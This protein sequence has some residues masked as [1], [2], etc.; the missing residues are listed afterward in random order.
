[1]EMISAGILTNDMDMGQALAWAIARNTTGMKLQVFGG[2]GFAVSEMGKTDVL[3][4]DLSLGGMEVNQIMNS[5][6]CIIY[7]TDDIDL[8]DVS[9]AVLY[10]YKN[11]RELLKDIYHIYSLASGRQFVADVE[12]E[13]KIVSFVSE[14][15]GSGCTA[16]SLAFAGE[17]AKFRDKRV[18]HISL[19]QFPEDDVIFRKS[20]VEDD[21][22]QEGYADE[23]DTGLDESPGGA[24]GSAANKRNIK[25]YLYYILREGGDDAGKI[26]MTGNTVQRG[27]VRTSSFL[28]SNEDG[29]W[30]FLSAPGENPILELDE[31][32]YVKFIRRLT[33]DEEYDVLVID[34]GSYITLQ[35]IKSLQMSSRIV[36]V[37]DDRG[38][39]A[40]WRK[41]L[42]RITGDDL[43]SAIVPAQRGDFLAGTSFAQHL[44]YGII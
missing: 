43:K 12:H 6:A 2:T 44:V 10:K 27:R 8:E 4:T 29:V 5:N 40:G 33:L 7:L 37:E 25:Q 21:E 28:Y 17:L 19:D 30:C 20:D 24:G 13:T 14:R 9:S 34:C 26:N 18:I 32:E 3:L 38:E 39:N 15:G 42:G 1:M 16:A 41:F 35:M 36:L 11:V 22:G 31:E 23:R